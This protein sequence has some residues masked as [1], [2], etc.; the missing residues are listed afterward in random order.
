MGVRNFLVDFPDAKKD[1]DRDFFRVEIE[2]NEFF[3]VTILIVE[4]LRV[5]RVTL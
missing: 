2:K 5:Q 3:S 4:L 1:S